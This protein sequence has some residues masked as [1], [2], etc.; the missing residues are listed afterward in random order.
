MIAW[1]GEGCRQSWGRLVQLSYEIFMDWSCVD[2]CFLSFSFCPMKGKET[3]VFDCGCNCCKL[4]FN[5]L[6][7]FS[8]NHWPKNLRMK[9]FESQ[10]QL[11]FVDYQVS[12]KGLDFMPAFSACQ[13]KAE[14]TEKTCFLALFGLVPT[15]VLIFQTCF[16]VGLG[17]LKTFKRRKI[18]WIRGWSSVKHVTRERFL[19]LG[20]F[21]RE[22]LIFR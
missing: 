19:C 2:N 8:P 21:A 15:G 16:C 5:H 3:G 10:L 18:L 20:L 7:F 22:G 17:V 9:G 11:T 6:D 4:L 13:F 1:V 14:F 12:L